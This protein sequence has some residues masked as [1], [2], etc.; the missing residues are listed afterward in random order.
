[1]KDQKLNEKESLEL[2]TRMI[3]NTR[4][5]LDNGSG[6][7]LIAAGG[8]ILLTTL[9]VGILY[10][11]TGSTNSFFIWNI[12]PF[13]VWFYYLRLP[14]KEEKLITHLDKVVT[15]IWANISAFC[16]AVP[17]MLFVSSLGENGI[18]WTQTLTIALICIE[19]L[20]V[21]LGL[22]IMGS[23]IKFKALNIAGIV[24][25][26]LAVL[27]F[28]LEGSSVIYKIMIVFVIWATAILI[29]PGIKLNRHIKKQQQC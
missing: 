22:G 2:I 1:M 5:N 17:A 18:E 26:V 24:G 27:S 6:N 28:M 15:S 4:T 7:M 11:F 12:I 13:V 21:S 14:K 8:G 20:L 16:L 3:A 19:M 9:L 29:I 10:Y 23:V 25:M